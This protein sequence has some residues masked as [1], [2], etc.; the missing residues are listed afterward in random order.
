MVEEKSENEHEGRTGE[1]RERER[2]RRES[3]RGA[4][5]SFARRYNTET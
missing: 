4:W 2:E 5:V 1:E 3:W